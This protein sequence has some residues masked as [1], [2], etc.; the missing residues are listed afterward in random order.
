VKDPADKSICIACSIFKSE[1]EELTARGEVDF[2]V[3]YLDSM[4][5]M[6]PAKLHRKL[7]SLLRGELKNGKRVILLYGNCHPHMMEQESLPRVCRVKGMNCPE[8][9]LGREA[10]RNL[11]RE[12]AFILLPEW[13][14]RWREI[15]ETEL[16]LEE[17]VAKDFM[18]DMHSKL[19]YLDSGNISV[20][21][22]HLMAL[23]DYTGLSW[24]VIPIGP[25]HLLAAI[26]EALMRMAENE[27]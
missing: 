3:R 6:D 5:H 19:L 24:E 17:K 22:E 11:R 15:F 25:D 4:L 27:R 26:R 9:L 21:A 2:P 12:G 10:Y 14:M 18:Q 13:T 23:S 1:L 7:D 16:G 20:P 8:I